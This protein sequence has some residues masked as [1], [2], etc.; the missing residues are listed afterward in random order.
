M[1]EDEKNGGETLERE[2]IEEQEEFEDDEDEDEE[3]DEDEADLEEADPGQL[4]APWSPTP[5]WPARLFQQQNQDASIDIVFPTVYEEDRTAKIKD[6]A[7]GQA[8][9]FITHRRAAEQA[10]KEFGFEQYDYSEEMKQIE[11]EQKA[12]TPGQ[13]GIA[14][15][16]AQSVVGLGGPKG[17][18]PGKQIIIGQP[19]PGLAAEDEDEE[20]QPVHRA[21]LSG[22]RTAAF[23]KDQRS[24]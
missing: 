2:E 22:D 18:P 14:D 16:I 10:A 8:L 5:T 11:E 7:T 3:G 4:D 13:L 12:L 6:L 1:G 23:R 17:A 24:L 9:G 20:E 21:E 15:Q 19:A